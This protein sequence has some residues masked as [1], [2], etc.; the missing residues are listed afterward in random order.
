MANV[1]KPRPYPVFLYHPDHEE[2]K[3]V[4]TAAELMELQTKGWVRRYLHKEYPKWVKG[5]LC[6]NKA[7][8]DRVLSAGKQDTDA[9]P[10]KKARKK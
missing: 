5:V 3:R 2:P 9:K 7:E 1:S 6:K 8:R 10:P 4:D